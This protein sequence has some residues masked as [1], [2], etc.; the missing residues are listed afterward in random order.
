[1][2][3]LYILSYYVSILLICALI[4]SFLTLI[5][6]GLLVIDANQN[7]AI[8]GG[9]RGHRGGAIAP[10]TPPQASHQTQLCICCH[11]SII[12]SIVLICCHTLVIISTILCIVH[13]DVSF[14]FN[15]ISRI[16]LKI[17]TILQTVD[18]VNDY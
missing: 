8:K 3:I 1:M 18:V 4:V 10:P 9:A 7:H 17:Q 14:S 12:I 16:M 6:I 15:N 13:L 2:F 11:T 5:F